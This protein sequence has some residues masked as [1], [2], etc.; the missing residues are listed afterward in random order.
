ME[1]AGLR[2]DVLLSRRLPDWS[3][4]QLQKLIRSGRVHIGAN[5]PRKTGE[6][7][8]T[9][10]R[11]V[12]RL[13]KENLRAAAPELLPLNVIYE[14]ADLA[15]INKPA[16][17]VVHAGAGVRSGTLVNALLY[18]MPQLS[19]AAGTDRPGIVHRLD[20]MTSG[21]ILVAKNDAA[22][23]R[24]AADFKAR[25]IRKSYIALVH[26]RV[27]REE[28]IIDAPIGRDPAHRMR[29]KAGG[30]HPR[31]SITA[32]RVLRCFAGFTLLQISPR[33]GR[34]HQIRVHLASLGHAVAGD[35]LYGARARARHRPED[36]E[37]PSRMFL[38]ASVLEFRHPRTGEPL[39]FEAPLPEELRN[40]LDRLPGS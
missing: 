29:M 14:D 21:L 3:R 38:H 25:A 17:M 26:G 31:P 11:I 2:L 22:H 15:V 39:V 32:Y 33:T 20:K 28:G 23:R 19:W 27:R 9:G 18:H 7:V 8:E 10:D 35:A 1:D 37:P 30:L 13:E 16:G 24:L 5:V 4:S 12:V 6:P 40:V 36:R 34:T